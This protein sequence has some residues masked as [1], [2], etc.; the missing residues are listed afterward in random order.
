LERV[1][2]RVVEAE[3]VPGVEQRLELRALRGALDLAAG[4]RDEAL[5]D[6]GLLDHG[7][8]G[9]GLREF[10][11]DVEAALVETLVAVPLGDGRGVPIPL[12]H[13]AHALAHRLDVVAGV[14]L[15]AL[16]LLGVREPRRA[17][18]LA[19]RRQ[20]LG[21]QQDELAPLLELRHVL[22]HLQ[23]RA[24]AGG[25][26]VSVRSHTCTGPSSTA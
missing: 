3:P 6:A 13:A 2:A 11:V 22:G 16:P 10:A 15:E 9:A 7:G 20:G 26:I 4:E 8:A 1:G 14:C 12:G 24:Q 17:A 5:G 19:V 18:Q 23:H 21:E 25:V